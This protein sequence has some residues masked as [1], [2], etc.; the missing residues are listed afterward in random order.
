MNFKFENLGPIKSGNIN[1]KDLTI[2][3]GENNTGK[4]YISYALY[5]FY[6]S[7]DLYFVNNID[8]TKYIKKIYD[9]NSY[10]INLED[11]YSDRYKIMLKAIEKYKSEIYNVFNST[12]DLFKDL[13]LD[14]EFINEYEDKEKFFRDYE[15]G[16][17]LVVSTLKK[18]MIIS[19]EGNILRVTS[20]DANTEN[21][22]VEIE[23]LI[24]LLLR[25][26][27]PIRM[28]R[29]DKNV[30]MLPA[31]R[32]GINIFF[33]ELNVNRNNEIFALNKNASMKKFIKKF[34]KYALPISDYLN[35]LNNMEEH[36]G[37]EEEF[38]NVVD[39]LEDGVICGKYLIDKDNNIR[40]L[41][42][43]FKENESIDFHIASSTAKTLFSLDY[44]LKFNAEKGDILIIDEP[45]LNLHPDNQRKLTRILVKMVNKGIKLIISTHSDYIIKEINNL[46]VLARKFNG[47]E[48]LMEKY[49]YTEDELIEEDRVSA[50]MIK[51]K[52]IIPAEIA[53]EGIIMQTF[54]EVINAYNKSSDEIYYKY[55]DCVEE[56]QENE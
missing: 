47:Y 40:F 28:S 44:Y 31:E 53:E 3:C 39:E 33:K 20:L 48:E 27:Y 9:S 16:F 21:D 10:E 51:N 4:T 36:D 14:V 15:D 46:I 2:I 1:V 52:T 19:R 22:E 7:F 6:K 8:S 5:G 55:I 11:L 37:G 42:K 29:R 32:S 23:E 34:S 50:Y 12:K 30:F 25:V 24:N 56:E 13:N 45:E 17:K 49:D 41:H 38:K 18:K 54:D 43:D 35:F 26:T